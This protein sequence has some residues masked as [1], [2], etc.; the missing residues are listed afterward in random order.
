SAFLRLSG[1]GAGAGVAGGAGRCPPAPGLL[2]L[3][4]ARAFV[5][6][7]PVSFGFFPY[8][9]CGPA[10]Q[11]DGLDELAPPPACAVSGAAVGNGAVRLELAGGP[12]LAPF[13]IRGMRAFPVPRVSACSTRHTR[14]CS[15]PGGSRPRARPRSPFSSAPACP[16]TFPWSCR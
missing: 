1:V 2:A 14:A 5:H 8:G 15:P 6:S 4:G 13:V 11:K 16:R 12:P 7:I 3:A 9:G 10:P